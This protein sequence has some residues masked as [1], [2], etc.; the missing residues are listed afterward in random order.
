EGRAGGSEARLARIEGLAG[1][2][3]E[4]L[5]RPAKPRAGIDGTVVF[6]CAEFGFHA[7]MPIYS[8]GL[9]V[10]AGDILKEASDQS[11]QMVGIGLLYRRGYFRQRLDL[12]G[13]QQE[14]WLALDPK[15]LP[16]ARVTAPHRSPLLL[17]IEVY[18]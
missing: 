2:I 4:M 13:R 8:G 14:Y 17:Q 9:G 3:D 11:L 16:L 15:S 1:R 7:S 5:S 6:M 18:R 12:A 10:L